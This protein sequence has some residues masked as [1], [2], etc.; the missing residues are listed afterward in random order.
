MEAGGVDGE[1]PLVS[2]DADHDAGEGRSDDASEVPLRGAERDGACEVF[3]ADE[4]RDHRLVR[5]KAQCLRA[6]REQH[7]QGDR[8]GTGGVHSRERAQRP[9][10]D[11]LQGGGR[12]EEPAPG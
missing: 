7:D 10:E 1:R 6:P 11:G 4:V 12:Q 8:R 2:A 3:P 5:G 9:G